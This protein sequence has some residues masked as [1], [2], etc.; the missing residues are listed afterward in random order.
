[1]ASVRAAILPVTLLVA[2]SNDPVYL[3][4]PAA[5][6]V[7][8]DGMTTAA[9]A[10]LTLPIRL[11]TEE[12]AAVRAE[13]QAELGAMVPLVTREAL[14]LSIEWTIKNLDDQPG[15]ARIHLNGANEWFAYVPLAFVV[16]PEEEEAPPPLAGDVP[17]E[18]PAG[19]TRSGVLREDQLAEA[20][21]DLELISRG[22]LGP[23]AALL[24]VHDDLEEIDVGGA[25]VPVG[26][27]ANL[28]RFDLT[29]IAD[30]HMVLEYTVRVRDHR[31][32]P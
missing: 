13:R 16:D 26:E 24:A 8:A 27:L 18:I 22:G 29:F 1:M 7:G 28:I 30:R 23:F 21:L 4:P 2:C 12:E 11:E 5:L 20:S 32:P 17:Y 9:S 10:Q 25:M 19:G 31:N 6:E 3:Q 14:D 15:V